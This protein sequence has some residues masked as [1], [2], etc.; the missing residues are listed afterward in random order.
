MLKLCP[1]ASS[2]V[3]GVPRR[4]IM[5]ASLLLQQYVRQARVIVSVTLKD[6]GPAWTVWRQIISETEG[7][8]W[9][10]FNSLLL[11]QVT[12]PDS[13]CLASFLRLL[14]KKKRANYGD[15]A[16]PKRRR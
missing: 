9:Q 3:S 6:K 4:L 1:L 16:F 5:Q 8:T 10:C 15:K 11:N 13:H 14:W 12:L 2:A 7:D